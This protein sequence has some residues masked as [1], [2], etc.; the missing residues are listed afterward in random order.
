MGIADTFTDLVTL[1][2]NELP[3]LRPTSAAGALYGSAWPG[4]PDV[5]VP[6]YRSDLGLWAYYTGTRW[7]S[8]QEHVALFQFP[9]L[10]TATIG[11]N[12]PIVGPQNAEISKWVVNFIIETGLNNSSNYWTFQLY[13][14]PTVTNISLPWPTSIGASVGSYAYAQSTKQ[15]TYDTN[16]SQSI[17]YMIVHKTLSPGPITVYGRVHYRLIIP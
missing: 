11:I 13:V 4:S 5:G 8:V 6:Y 15:I 3:Q 2:G 9:N 16:S 12:A 1:L 10:L 17:F 7:L 14:M